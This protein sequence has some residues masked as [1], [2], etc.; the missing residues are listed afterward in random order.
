MKRVSRVVSKKEDIDFLLNLDPDEICNMS[1][2]MDNFCSFKKGDLPRF[3]PYDIFH[4]PVGSYGSPTKKNTNVFTT[5]VGLWVF[6][7]A[8]IEP[9]LFDLLGY[10]NEP[11]GKK[12]F[13]K[14]NKK[15]SYAL[16][17]DKIS[18]DVFREYITKTQKFQPY[19]TVLA[20]SVT[21]TCLQIPSKIRKL[22][23][24][25]F[26]K[27][28]KELAAND[29][30]VATKIEKELLAECK[31]ILKDDEFMDLVN[32]EAR[33]SFGNNF[34]NMY[35]FRGAIRESDPTK[36]GFT[37]IKSNYSEGMS[38]EDYAD[39]ANSLTAGPYSRAK[40]TAVGGYYEKGM[41][42]AFQHLR[43]L[44]EGTDCGTKRTL[45]VTLT[46]DNI[47]SWMYS[48]VVGPNGQLTEI[49]T[50]TQD[51]FIGK[52]VKLRYAALCESKEGI[53]SKCSGHLFNRIGLDEV[54]IA[55]YQIMS[56]IKNI[57][58]KAF[59]D[60]T[61]KILDLEEEYGLNRAFGLE[62]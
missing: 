38:A 40:K 18:I 17:E 27:Y 28:E 42:K 54:G 13:G 8:F 11:I 5:T 23:Q 46:K 24:E 41:V 55:S 39:F 15:L 48:Y 30:I 10:V 44:P 35:V 53:C 37:I 50:D 62:E 58:M 47:D 59:H 2:M 31:K 61:I 12:T 6:N 1:F 51:Q 43:A 60:S 49:T 29:P 36:P 34:K 56:V 19:C 22:K 21:T 26:K 7:K 33:I 9:H 16:V 14:L 45:P 52:T 3:Y 20:P 4:V 25:L 57:S 32:S